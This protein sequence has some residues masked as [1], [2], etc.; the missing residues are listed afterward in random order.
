MTARLL[1]PAEA[2][3]SV[4]KHVVGSWAERVCAEMTGGDQQTF[5][6][7][8]RTGITG[9]ASVERLG[10]GVWHDWRVAWD[11]VDLASVAGS[12]LESTVV[13]V[14]GNSSAAPHRV[15]VETLQAALGTVKLLGGPGVGVD[16]IAHDGSQP[17]C[18]MLARS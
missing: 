9:S 2:A 16:S 5:T 10:F 13:T 6:V 8:V 4:A 11:R 7:S 3:A 17:G 12:R 18:V 1:G 15:H 14:A